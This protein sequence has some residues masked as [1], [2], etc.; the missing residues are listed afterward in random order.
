MQIPSEIDLAKLREKAKISQSDM[1]ERLG[2]SQSQVSRYEQDPEEVPYR[3]IRKWFALC[4]FVSS[5][6]GL[7]VGNPFDEIQGRMKLLVDYAQTEPDAPVDKIDLTQTTDAKTFINSVKTIARKPRVGLCGVI[8]SGKSR[9][10]NI[11]LGFDRLPAGF[12]PTTSAICLIRHISDKP[13]WQ[14]EDVWMMRRG[15]DV[16]LADD[17]DHCKGYRLLSGGYESLR[18]YGT[19][20]GSGFTHGAYVAVIYIDSP[21]LMGCD[22]LDFPGYDP[23]AGNF[24]RAEISKKLIDVLIYTSSSNDFLNQADINYLGALL[25]H[26]PTYSAIPG[27]V[28]PLRNLMIVATKSDTIEKERTVNILDGGS[29]YVFH[30]LHHVISDLSRITNTQIT[31]EDLRRRF[32]TFTAVDVNTRVDPTDVECD[33]IDILSNALPRYILAQMNTH[34]LNAKILANQKCDMRIN[35]LRQLTINSDICR[36]AINDMQVDE[37]V[38]TH[39]RT[40]QLQHIDAIIAKFNTEC[41]TTL[42]HSFKSIYTVDFIQES[43]ENHFRENKKE[44][45]ELATY[46]LLN[47]I[48]NKIECDVKDKADRIFSEVNLLLEEYNFPVKKHK[49][50][51]AIWPFSAL[52]S[53]ISE[54]QK[55]AVIGVLGSYINRNISDNRLYSS[56]QSPID[57]TNISRKFIDTGET[58][59]TTELLDPIWIFSVN[60]EM[61][62]SFLLDESWQQ[63]LAKRIHKQIQKHEVEKAVVKVLDSF[64]EIAKS[65]ITDAFDKVESDYI[66]SLNNIKSLSLSTDREKL[67]IDLDFSQELRDFFGGIPWKSIKNR[68]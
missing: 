47:L 6:Q 27:N 20:T 49:I 39:E 1:A 15:F 52:D 25:R 48:Q 63:K 24:D 9:L 53:F 55:H 35:R 61:Q 62:C 45:Q 38:R 50:M 56:S 30:N 4:G 8:S 68:L 18:Q 59:A 13:A 28:E 31:Q 44:A 37:L 19:Y 51:E 43:I 7:D 66:S 60:R 26:L 3:V 34:I 36:T 12:D 58:I 22:L 14:A 64:W 41:K 2:L 32:F 46:Y 33:L 11:I 67:K 17:E 5:T 10:G 23:L 40:I 65:V 16:N 42:A 57:A 29:M 54:L 21:M